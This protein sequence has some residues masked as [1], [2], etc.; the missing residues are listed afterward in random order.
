[1]S[2]P[3]TRTAG[4]MPAV[5]GGR[6]ARPRLLGAA[7]LVVASLAVPAAAQWRTVDTFTIKGAHGL[8]VVPE[9]WNGGL[10]IY[11]HGY[12]RDI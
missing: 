1:M 10:F 6:S 12:S 11:A 7:A 3:S 5:R 9:N 8:I 2:D 4:V